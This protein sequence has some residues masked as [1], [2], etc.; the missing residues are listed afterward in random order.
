LTMESVY[1]ELHCHSNFSLLDGASHPEDLVS[2]AAA[3]GFTALALTDH[4]GLY[5]AIRFHKACREAGIKPI[6]GAELTLEGGSHITLLAKDHAGY[7]N[8]CRL[9]TRA[10]ISNEKDSPA[11][12]FNHLAQHSKGLVCL[13][14]CRKGEVAG[15]ILSGKTNRAREAGARFLDIF[16]K[17]NFRI[18]L[19]NNYYPE[20]A[21]LIQAL[22][23]IAGF[24]GV[25]CVATNN[26]HYAGKDDR[27]LHDVLVS[28]RNKSTL[29][30]C[31]GLRLN[32][33]FYLKSPVEMRT[34]FR[35]YPEAVS[36]TVTV[37]EACNVSLDFSAYRFPEFPVPEGE[38]A[39][40]YLGKVCLEKLKQ[41]YGVFDPEAEKRLR[42]ELDLIGRLD[43]AGYFL[44]VWD[45]ME[46]ARK[47]GIPAQGRGSAANS[48]VAYILG[49][50]KVDPIKN[51]LFL[52]RFLNE[53]MSSL[54]D[55]DID[56]ST[57]HREELIQYVYQKYGREHTAMVCTYVT[58]QARNAIREVGKVL[59]LPEAL[60][61]GMAKSVSSY[62][63]ADI[64]DDLGRL[65]S[66]RKVLSSG[67]WQEFISLCGKIADFPRHLSIHVGGMLISSCP[68]TDIVP[69]EKATMP[70]RVVCQWDKDGV[71]DA[72]LIKM[73]LLGLRMLSLIE[74]ARQM[75]ETS[76]GIRL[77]PDEL[78]Q[79][80]SR[81]YDMI[82]KADTIGV[83][84]V[85]SRAQI[86]TLPQTQPRSIEDLTIE[87]AIIRPG[88]LQG[89]MVHP[90]L[91]RR[92]GREEVSYLH[93]KLKSILEETLG[94]I[95]FQ[96]QVIQ[97]AVLIAGFS[98][99]EADALRRAMSRK[100]SR[101]EMGKLR[102]RFLKGAD[103]NGVDE[104][105]A[106]RIFASLEG[107]AEY[108]FCK[109]HAAG[110]ALLCYQSAWLK[111][112]YPAEFYAALLNNQ[113]MGFYTPD[114]IVNDAKRHGVAVLPVDVNRSGDRCSVE[115]GRVR[116]G[117]RFVKGIGK[118]ADRLIRERGNRPFSSL[119]D[120]F[121]RVPLD[122]KDFEN[123]ILAGAFDS[124]EPSRRQM[125]WQ[126][127]LLEK[128]VPGVLPLK[129]PASVIGLPRFSDLEE[130]KADYSVLGL[131]PKH[132][133]MEVLRKRGAG[134]AMVTSSGTLR[135]ADG[136]RVRAAGYVI[137]RQTPGTAKGF[138]F[139]TLEDEEGIMN[140]VIRP[141]VYERHRQVFRLEPV[142][143][144]EGTLQKKDGVINIIAERLAPFIRQEKRHRVF[145]QKPS[146]LV[147]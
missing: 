39:G 142:I 75:V 98:A 88:P 130:M 13:S 99:G 102:Q 109:S 35:F 128:R 100:R 61:D 18:E 104:G 68:L 80:D 125:L 52:G 129:F 31:R 103:S 9:I 115:E 133:P 146:W 124:F 97:A 72:G 84:Q 90:Y 49:I 67:I 29:D 117:F 69:L 105:T 66:F 25:H 40:G 119:E 42:Y 143:L 111:T 101:H 71:A 70:G 38:S 3:L 94:V 14:G 21:A 112:Y 108:G 81:V 141:A 74:E 83:F 7:S 24:L 20:D 22:T 19:Q 131:S 56:I 51:K 89:N 33:E 116:L 82:S 5:G 2:R 79:D 50:T 113:P 91:Q 34:L 53:E 78:P 17:E 120:L 139:L 27:R 57:N 54:P 145:D 77:N 1:A 86:Q 16:G 106:E 6:I 85:E 28:I 110:F 8:L 95:L 114:V 126:F 4:N 47:S 46:Y 140:V 10:R 138:R 92:K 37:A 135:L 123:L 30:Q 144:V 63:A 87:V 136:A 121:V 96:E 64:E 15:L 122:S 41:R 76:K 93:P 58:F 132:H 32:A 55:I 60:L 137:S 147:K 59:G 62:G 134:R 23:E 45:I 118:K 12:C 127:G 44:I 107:F 11:L 73:D 43:L 65:D 48:I 36:S 26:V